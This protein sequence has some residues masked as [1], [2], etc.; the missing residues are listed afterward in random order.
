[1]IRTCFAVVLLSLAIP[2]TSGAQTLLCDMAGESSQGWIAPQIAL[3]INL[4][5]GKVSAN[6]MITIG[7][8]G[9]P[10]EGEVDSDNASRTVVKWTVR[11]RDNTQQSATLAY[12]ATIM[13]ADNSIAVTMRP[14]QYSN[15]FRAEGTCRAG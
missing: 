4:E 14:L 2:A 8:T 5:T 3:S 15:S 9:G 7:F 1:M 6:D 10:V 11:G 13:K 12:R